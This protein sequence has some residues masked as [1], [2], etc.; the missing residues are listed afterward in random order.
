[1]LKTSWKLFEDEPTKKNS[2]S[3]K[4]SQYGSLVR[5]TLPSTMYFV[6][7]FHRN[8]KCP[9]DITAHI[10]SFK[11]LYTK[12]VKAVSFGHIL[13]VIQIKI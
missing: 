6:F 3:L 12:S 9:I 2:H 13:N 11:F 5:Y 4:F 8:D 7:N 10:I 1:M